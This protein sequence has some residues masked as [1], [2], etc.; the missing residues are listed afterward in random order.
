[1]VNI[2]WAV[3]LKGGNKE[4]SVGSRI[5]LNCNDKSQRSVYKLC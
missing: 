3:G 1:M 4:I 2:D 5:P